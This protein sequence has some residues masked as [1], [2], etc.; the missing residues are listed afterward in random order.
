[1]GRKPLHVPLRIYLNNR[2]VGHLSKES[3][4]ATMFRYDETWLNRRG[5]MPVSLSLP[6]R[7]DAY[8]GEPVSAVFENLLPDSDALRRRVAEKVG[9][10]GT[11]AYSLLTKIGR[12]CVGDKEFEF[13]SNI[14]GE[15]VDTAQI[16]TL[17]K[18]LAQAPLGLNRDDDFRISVAGAQEKTALLWHEGQW[19][20]PHGMTPTTHIFKTQISTLPNGLD[21]MDSVENEFYCLSLAEA[22]GLPVNA[23]RIETFG[24]TKALVIERFDR[25]WTDSGRLIWL[26]QEDCC[27]ALSVPPT[28]K[29][30]S[31]GGPGMAAIL[32][33]LKGSDTPAEDQK[34]FLIAQ[35]FFWIIGA[36]D[37]HAK[38]FSVFLLPG[39]GFHMTPLYDILSAQPSLDRRQIERKQMKL[40]MSVGRNRH[41]RIDQIQ[42]RHFMQMAAVAN[43]P[44]SV[45][46][47]AMAHVVEFGALAFEAV[48]NKL[49]ADF[50]EEIHTSVNAAAVSRLHAFE[51][52]ANGGSKAE[53]WQ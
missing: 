52:I 43:I 19:I 27:Q 31:E 3:G 34:C 16:E 21:L 11:D 10:R 22:F 47:T 39:G 1:M 48:A 53:R 35:M 13:D 7:E 50:P 46:R 17:L 28:L 9:A 25:R 41:Y 4:G 15:P 6:L 32:D 30:Q 51:R 45:V 18:N 5:V 23:T 8:R 2:L 37:G 36:T 20:K 12:D 26:P 40:A 38:N 33:L 24:E 29:Y 42:P 49:P 44:E 14:S